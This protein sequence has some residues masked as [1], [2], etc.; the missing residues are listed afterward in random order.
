MAHDIASLIEQLRAFTKARDWAQFH[1]P[2]NLAC[3]LS[4]EAAELLEHFQWMK[5]EESRVLSDKKLAEVTSELADIF[6]YLLYIADAYQVDL[7]QATKDK[8]ALNEKRYPAEK[9]K[10]NSLKYDELSHQK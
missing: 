7:I 1:S 8:I 10:G 5:E 2:K 4:V 9:A 6:S 3:A